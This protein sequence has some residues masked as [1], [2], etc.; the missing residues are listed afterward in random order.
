M[1]RILLVTCLLLLVTTAPAFAIED[2]GSSRISPASPF[3]FLKTIKENFELK[4][5]ATPR[6]T[7][8]R[9]LEFATRRLREVKSL[10]GPGSEALIEPT[11]ERYWYHLQQVTEQSKARDTLSVHLETLQGFYRQIINL[12][13]KMAV[14]AAIN[15]IIQRVDVPA[16]AKATACNFLAQ[17]ASS[18]ALTRVEK[19]VLLDRTQKCFN[20]T[21]L[22]PLP[23]L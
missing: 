8:I 18:S 16:G 19:A 21:Y 12:R 22:N 10:I 3:Y 2:I 7:Q 1:S 23:N 20:N 14:R 6:V 15:R 11:L 9:Q 17:E 13:A 5:S 4:F